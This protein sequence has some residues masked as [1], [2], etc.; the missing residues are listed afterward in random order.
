M[1]DSVTQG[2]EGHQ[3]PIAVQPSLLSYAKA[4][5]FLGVDR[6]TIWR[7]Q[8]SGRLPVIRL[9]SRTVRFRQSDLDRLVESASQTA[10]SLPHA[11]E[12]KN[13]I[14]TTTETSQPRGDR[15]AEA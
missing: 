11:N 5:R 2:S 3:S 10:P 8:R 14:M 9:T 12:V 4:A 15:R 1:K 13:S 7:F 6:A